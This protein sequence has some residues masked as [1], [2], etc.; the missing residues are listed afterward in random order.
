MKKQHLHKKCATA[1]T[2][3]SPVVLNPPTT[4]TI[5][6]KLTVIAD[7]SPNPIEADIEIALPKLG[8]IA[9]APPNT[10]SNAYSTTQPKRLYIFLTA[11]APTIID[12]MADQWK[13]VPNPTDYSL[14]D[15]KEVLKKICK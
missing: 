4:I 11:A 1:C 5:D 6:S 14:K 2:T 8:A 12:G 3:A 13:P 7:C 15:V 9:T 10:S